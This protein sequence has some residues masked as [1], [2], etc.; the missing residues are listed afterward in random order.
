[1]SDSASIS[2]YLRQDASNLLEMNL[3]GAI[4]LSKDF[5]FLLD[6]RLEISENN[7][8]RWATQM[9]MHII[10]RVSNLERD[11]FTNW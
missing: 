6:S 1:M 7:V 4:G 10:M 3:D 11:L 8:N 9:C 2:D 5:E